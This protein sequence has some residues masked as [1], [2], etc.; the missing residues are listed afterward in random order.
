MT[1]DPKGQ[2]ANHVQSSWLYLTTSVDCTN[3][4]RLQTT[5]NSHLLGGSTKQSHDFKTR[6]F[7]F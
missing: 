7:N 3:T 5:A 6:I 2:G 1:K 4:T